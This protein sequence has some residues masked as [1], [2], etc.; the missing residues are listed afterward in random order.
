MIDNFALA[1]SHGL[2]LLVAWRLLKRVDLD[3]EPSDEPPPFR[4]P[5]PGA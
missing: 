2:L 4:R 3:I 1:L 5:P